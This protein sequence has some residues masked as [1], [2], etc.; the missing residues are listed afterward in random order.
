MDFILRGLN[1]SNLESEIYDLKFKIN[2]KRNIS[3]LFL[4][5]MRYF[6]FQHGE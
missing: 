4:R 2:L 6:I 1:I 5:Q 3:M